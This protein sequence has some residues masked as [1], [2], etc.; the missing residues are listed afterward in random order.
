MA[1]PRLLLLP[2][3]FRSSFTNGLFTNRSVLPKMKRIKPP[4]SRNSSG[5]A[6]MQSG[7]TVAGAIPI[8]TNS[9]GQMPY[10]VRYCRDQCEGR[11]AVR[12]S[13]RIQTGV[14]D[15]TRCNRRRWCLRV[16]RAV[17][18]GTNLAQRYQLFHRFCRLQRG[19]EITLHI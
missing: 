7:H 5:S 9:A 13:V 6:A 3:D 14:T 19:L 4:K 10:R 17:K 2:V 18:S 12:P 8:R 15:V 11:R 16:C 1:A